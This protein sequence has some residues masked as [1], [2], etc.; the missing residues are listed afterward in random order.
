MDWDSIK[1]LIGTSAPVLGTLIGGPAGAAVGSIVGGLLGV[2]STPEAIER[3]LKGNPEAL[4]KLKKYEMDHKEKL[5]GMELDELKAYLGDVQSARKRQTDH[6]DKTGKTDKNLYALA[7]LTVGGFFG[8]IGIMMF[9]DVPTQNYDILYMLLGAL[10]AK[11]GSV[12]NYFFGTS[13][14]SADKNVMLAN[15]KKGG[16]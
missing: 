13:K 4:L 2:D 16:V 7:W 10:T 8:L 14:G 3:E 5:Q 9:V 6:E 11:T 12:Y 15:T 1:K